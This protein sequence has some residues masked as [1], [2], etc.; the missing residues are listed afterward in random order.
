[1]IQ[2]HSFFSLKYGLVSPKELLLTSLKLGFS[3]F[4]LADI[5]NTSGCLEFVREA[6]NLG[7]RPIIGIDFRNGNQQLYTAIARN[8]QGFQ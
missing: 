1:M 2:F 8:N 4:L 6:K 5:N 7:I 3:D